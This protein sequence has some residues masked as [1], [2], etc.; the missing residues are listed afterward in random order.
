[1]ARQSARST[2]GSAAGVARPRSARGEGEQLRREILAAVNR[3][4]DHWGGIE[5]LTMRAVAREV[6]VAAPS[7]YLHFSDKAELVWAALENK[8][9][10]LAARMNAAD[11][12]TDGQD[13]RER[14]R[15]Q[16][17]AYCRF[18]LD[19]PGHYRLL[20]EVPQPAVAEGRINRHPSRHVSASLRSA[21]ARCLDEG[22]TPSLPVEQAALTL[23]SGLHGNIAMNHAL[24]QS[25]PMGDLILQV[26]D[27]LVDS[28]VP[29]PPTDG[30]TR[31]AAAETAASRRIRA[32]LAGLGDQ[33]AREDINSE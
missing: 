2:G 24:P 15:A 5:K 32:I 22:F 9:A 18:A 13:A 19:N 17:H 31:P 30:T 33:D 10:D 12:T 4:L 8:Y 16:V 25:A 21:L 29:D 1:M 28:L 26:A 11:T 27:G 23:W 3:L 7:I 20:F 6:G 14:L